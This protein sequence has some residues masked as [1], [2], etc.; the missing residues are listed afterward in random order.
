METDLLLRQYCKQL[1]LP[2][3]ATHYQH[4]A[5]DAARENLTY[6]PLSPGALGARDPAARDQPGKAPPAPGPF[7]SP[8]RPGHVRTL[9]PSSQPFN[10]TRLLE[11]ALGALD[12]RASQT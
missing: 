10:K 5:E 12:R 3:L 1:H 11:L 4:F 8:L 7:P 2:A 9:A 6:E